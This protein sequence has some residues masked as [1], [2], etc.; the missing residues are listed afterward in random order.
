[1]F[2]LTLDLPCNMWATTLNINLV[3]VY[4]PFQPNW[5]RVRV[6][7]L[8]QESNTEVIRKRLYQ[9]DVITFLVKRGM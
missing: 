1:M 2:Y 3:Y 5:T 6:L 7:T 9:R 4:S 8:L